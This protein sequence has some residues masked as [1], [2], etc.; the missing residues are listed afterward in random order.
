MDAVVERQAAHGRGAALARSVRACR[1][2]R[3]LRDAVVPPVRAQPT[4]RPTP[5]ARVPPVPSRPEISI[6][7]ACTEKRL[8]REGGVNESYADAALIR[9]P[10]PRHHQ[11]PADRPHQLVGGEP[12]G[13][14]RPDHRAGDRRRPAQREQLPVHALG[15]VP[16]HA[17]DADA[18]AHDE[19][20]A[21][22]AMRRLAHALEQG[23]HPQRAEDQA[24]QPAEHSDDRAAHHRR[25]DVERLLRLDGALPS[26]PEQVDAE[27]EEGQP[28]HHEQRVVR[29]DSAQVGAGE[30]AGH[31]RRR[32]PAEQA[33]VHPPRPDVGDRRGG[34]RHAGDADVRARPRGR[35]GGGGQHGGQADVPEH[36]A[37]RG[38]RRAPRRS[39][40]PPAP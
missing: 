17:G 35:A 5:H 39:T 6:E 2:P 33:P 1:S 25:P 8:R 12:A 15:R 29:H 40:T 30:R 32:H 10:T 20:R 21:H 7:R 19:V 26:R 16:D 9:I 18:D 27:V 31:R 22:G 4:G 13:E 11:Q 36:Q 24:H 3:C 37:R 38:R 34:R 23:G 14:P 28:D